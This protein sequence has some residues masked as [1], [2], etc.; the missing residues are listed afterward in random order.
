MAKKVFFSFHFDRDAWRVGQVRNCQVVTS[1]YDKPQFLDAVDWEKIR[2]Q[3]DPAIKNWIDS[4]L[5]GTSVTVVL[6]GS[7]T[8]ER[9]WVIYEIE[10][11]LKRGNTL[12]GIYIHNM[13]NS[14]GE[15]DYQGQNP[16]D[17]VASPKHLFYKLSYHVPTYNWVN[18]DGRTNIGAW[19]EN[20]IRDK[21]Y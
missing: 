15:T 11:S 8:S 3:G 19:I 21:N 5:V 17:F 4:Q 1:N 2:K 20:A 16:F 14:D 9:K 13:K 6:I 18:G 10:Q 7:Q 12:L